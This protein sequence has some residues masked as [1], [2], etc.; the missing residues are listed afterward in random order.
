MKKLLALLIT[1]SILLT[2][3]AQT[4][5]VT[6]KITDANGAPL[7]GISVII[8][9]TLSGT[10]TAADGSFKLNV[11]ENATLVFS[12]VGYEATEMS[13]RNRTVLDVQ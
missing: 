4:K 8:K 3:Y 2:A 9:G 5:S 10:T 1:T 7:Q 6:G 11:P 12:G 13:V